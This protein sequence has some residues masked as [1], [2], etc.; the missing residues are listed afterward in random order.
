MLGQHLVDHL[1][2]SAPQFLEAQ[3]VRVEY[4]EE[5]AKRGLA[6]RPALGVPDVVGDEVDA[7]RKHSSQVSGKFKSLNAKDA[8]EEARTQSNERTIY[9][10]NGFGS[11]AE[12]I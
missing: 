8:K 4:L 7:G 6:K 12:P 1:L 11:D 5:L 3:H 9:R 2:R 10:A